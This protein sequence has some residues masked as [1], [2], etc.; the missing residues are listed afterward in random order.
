MKT[1]YISYANIKALHPCAGELRK[2]RRL[3]GKRK[4]MIVT[5]K[6]AVALASRFDFGWLATAGDQSFDHGV[7]TY[8]RE[9]IWQKRQKLGGIICDDGSNVC[10]GSRCSGVD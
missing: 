9:C 6:R 8:D 4:R 10:V 1:V 2:V 5:V 7:D 3:F